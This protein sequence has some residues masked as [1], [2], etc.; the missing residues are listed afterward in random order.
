MEKS[1]SMERS[2]WTKIAFGL[3]IAAIAARIILGFF[4]VPLPAEPYSADGQDGVLQTVTITEIRRCFFAVSADG[5][6]CYYYIVKTSDGAEG[7]LKTSGNYQDQSLVQPPE[8]DSDRL[9]NFSYWLT[10]TG[11]SVRLPDSAAGTLEEQTRFWE[12]ITFL[13]SYLESAGG[14]VQDAYAPF[15]GKVALDIDYTEITKDN[16]ACLWASIACG[17]FFV[18]L[19]A[20]LLAEY[21]SGSRG[22][23]QAEDEKD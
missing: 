9:E 16:P 22:R 20:L 7:Y 17:V 4:P 3:L 19:M 6:G 5:S 1:E 14:R 11:M 23:K 18:W 13:P 8:K 15:S 21:F 10:L 12:K 2:T